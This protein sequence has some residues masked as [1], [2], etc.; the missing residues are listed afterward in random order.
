M[1]KPKSNHRIEDN[2][3]P[4]NDEGQLRVKNAKAFRQGWDAYRKKRTLM[5]NPYP[6]V[7]ESEERR[8]QFHFWRIGWRASRWAAQPDR[9]NYD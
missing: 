6:E 2:D 4:P 1:T 9:A 3:I 7:K 8:D 5:D